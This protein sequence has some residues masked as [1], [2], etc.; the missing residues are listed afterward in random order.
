MSAVSP[1]LLTPP[2]PLLSRSLNWAAAPA[3][4]TEYHLGT[5]KAKLAK[6]RQQLL[7]PDKKSKPGEGALTALLL[8]LECVPTS[9]T[10]TFPALMRAG[11]DVVKF[12]DGRVC[13]I[14]R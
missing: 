2:E 1:V 5:L 11:F 9:L 7:E 8:Q 10:F 13:L 4:A 14:V 12:G 3:E 6:Y